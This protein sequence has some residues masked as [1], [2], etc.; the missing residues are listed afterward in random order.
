MN[1][2]DQKSAGFL[3]WKPVCYRD[4]RQRSVATKVKNYKLNGIQND[5]RI[6]ET[7]IAY[8]HFGKDLFLPSVVSS[9]ATNLSFGMSGDGAYPTTNYTSW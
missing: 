4:T 6:L 7:S 2:K 3:Q 9:G 5:T 8:A 1:P